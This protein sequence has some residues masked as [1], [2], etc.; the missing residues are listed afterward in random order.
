MSSDRRPLYL[1]S[2][3]VNPEKE[4]QFNQ[5]YAERHIPRL[6]R[7]CPLFIS[8]KRFRLANDESAV[9]NQDWP[10]YLTIYELESDEVAERALESM[11]VPDREPD[12]QEWVDW[13]PY[14]KEVEVD[15]FSQIYPG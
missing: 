8:A 4:V 3:K 2:L 10:R 15:V 14:L 9:S 11:G 1:V 7:Y 13:Q 6:L 5:W 12:H